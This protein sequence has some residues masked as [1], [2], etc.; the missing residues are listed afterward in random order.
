[1]KSLPKKIREPLKPVLEKY[2][3]LAGSVISDTG[4]NS[5]IEAISKVGF[6][7]KVKAGSNFNP[8]EY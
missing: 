2:T 8:Q 7:F 1:M 6:W 3:S 5:N 4:E